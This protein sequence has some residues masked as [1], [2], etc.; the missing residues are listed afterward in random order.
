MPAIQ[1]NLRHNNYRENE[2]LMKIIGAIGENGSGKDEILK[3]LKEQFNVPFLG[4]GDM[5]RDIA[6]MEGKEPTRDNL[7]EISSRYFQQFGNGYFVKL[8]AERIK[9]N[10]WKV[11]GISGIRSL[12]DVTILKEMLGINFI[13]VSVTVSDQKERFRRMLSRGSQ[14]DPDTYTKFLELDAREESIF[15]IRE[16]TKVADYRITNDGSLQDL[17]KNIEEFVKQANLLAS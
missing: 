12:D 3:Y 13:L 10:G 9:K 4:T 15:K 16:A 8:V 7:G 1:Y 14:R 11:A 6:R 2:F 5:V 17:H